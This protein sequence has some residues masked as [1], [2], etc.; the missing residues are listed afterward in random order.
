MPE[1]SVEVQLQLWSEAVEQYLAD[2]DSN[3]AAD[4]YAYLIEG[5]TLVR[6]LLKSR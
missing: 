2:I 5:V 4:D 6:E 3:T 1:Y